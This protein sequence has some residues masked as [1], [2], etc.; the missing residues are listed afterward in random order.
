MIG[1]IGTY[2]SGCAAIEIPILNKAP[3]GGLAMVSPGNTLIC[4]TETSPICEDGQPESLYPTGTRNYVRVVPND[5]VQGAGL[6]S[7]AS[8][9]RGRQP[10]HPVTPP[11]IRPARDRPTPS[12]AP[13]RRSA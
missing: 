1:V 7:F 6:A 10:V 2:N 12:R 13:P 5:A 11:T 8:E 3:N 4:L 9:A